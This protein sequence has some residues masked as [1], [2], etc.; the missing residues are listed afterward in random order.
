MKDKKLAQCVKKAFPWPLLPLCSPAREMERINA[1]IKLLIK[2]VCR[3][4]IGLTWVCTTVAASE[5]GC[6]NPWFLSSHNL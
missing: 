2:S 1:A 3:W 4:L 5:P 6:L